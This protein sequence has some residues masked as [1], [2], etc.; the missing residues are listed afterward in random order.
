M[1]NK[2]LTNYF[3][4]FIFFILILIFINIYI[5]NKYIYIKGN[6][7]L[8]KTNLILDGDIKSNDIVAPSIKS[9]NTPFGFFRTKE[10]LIKDL[11]NIDSLYNIIELN[12]LDPNKEYNYILEFNATG[13]PTN[14]TIT[15]GYQTEQVKEKVLEKE[16]K[17]VNNIDLTNSKT[18]EKSNDDYISIPVTFQTNENGHSSIYIGIDVSDLS[19]IKYELSKIRFIK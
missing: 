1:K 15:V 16:D 9:N 6:D 4:F 10:I 8:S 17:L 2:T 5:S 12:N 7:L 14:T 19:Y 3:M 11:E 13:V 18:F